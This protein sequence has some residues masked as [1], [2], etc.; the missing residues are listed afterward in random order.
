[1]SESL[2]PTKQALLVIKQLQA[3]IEALERA[4]HE[5]I[6]IIGIGCRFP[7]GVDNPAAFWDLLRNGRDAIVEIPKNRW[8]IE[9]LY[10]SNPNTAGKMYTRHGGF[11]PHLQEFDA[12][13]FGISPREAASLDPQQRLLLE[14]TWEALENAC[15][16]P[17]QLSD[18]QTGVF[19]GICGND[20]WH[21]LLSRKFTEIDAYLATGN[22]H[23]IASGRLSY[24]LGCN[25][26]S[27]S[28]D[29]ACS[30]SLVALHLAV[31]SLRHQ[32]CHVA[33][34]GG[35][36]RIILPQVSINFSKA[37]MLSPDGSCKT[38]DAAANGFVRGEGCGII[39]LKRMSDAVASGDRI[40][41]V[42]LGSAVNHDG[43]SSGL[44]VP[45]GS[46]QEKLIQQALNN[47]GVEPA[48]ID[49]IETHGTG[50]ALGD[51]IE[52]GALG[53]IFSQKAR[54]DRPLMVGSVKTN[55]GHLEAAAGIAGLIKVVLALQKEE[56][57][58]H[59]HFQKPNPHI[60]WDELQ[61]VVPTEV[62]SW[63]KNA[64]Q[65]LA[66]VSSFG[67][68]G[69][70]AHAI[71][72]EAPQI[73][74]SDSLDPRPL[75]ILTISAKSDPA[76]RELAK[77]YTIW[78]QSTPEVSLADVCFT[79]NTGRS[80][81]NYRLSILASSIPEM[82]AK[83]AG[84]SHG[85]KDPGLFSGRVTDSNRPKVV[86]LFTGAGFQS[87]DVRHL[88]E[89]QP[90]FRSHIDY[91]AEI[92]EP[93]LETSL[94]EVLYPQN[95]SIKINE[96]PFPGLALFSLQYA[97]FQLWKSWGI[98]PG[99]VIGDDVGEY[100]AACVAGVFSL[101][102]G[103]KLMVVR[104][105]LI[106]QGLGITQEKALSHFEA[107]IQE[108]KY[109]KPVIPFISLLTGE[110][111]TDEIALADY[112]RDRSRFS[113]KLDRGINY[114]HEAGFR[115]FLEITFLPEIRREY[116]RENQGVWLSSLHPEVA[117]WQQMLTTL[118]Q[119]YLQGVPVD[120][121][122]FHRDYP[123]HRVVLPTYPFQR[124]RYWVELSEKT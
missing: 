101:E 91:C 21:H 27:L 96:T 86:F 65:R 95:K 24:I 107:G 67:F 104:E 105:K 8:N 41:A 114:L 7:G 79:S 40:L 16:V 12:Q 82:L 88:Y 85:E 15:I 87:L 76:L 111:A 14:V 53:R 10:D 29:T 49:Y 113:L 112:W 55:I 77:K 99:A 6:A 2:S 37:R 121:L 19:M 20:Y 70:N 110:F 74:K 22:S 56:I 102:D 13:F 59:L 93:D 42:I 33:I 124:Q 63:Q 97:L 106:Q 45:N 30:S 11:V 51:P 26:P 75:H 108:V 117:D 3:K 50:T 64:R 5:A 119:L 4:N 68:S 38:F 72:G 48:Q 44:T 34:V 115:I 1:M 39:V 32:E 61:L 100:V 109:S 46:S 84:F 47:S 90:T 78:L 103:L 62:R 73:G 18:S 71:L 17:N 60:N 83:L 52:I 116:P 69:T 36:N 43:K 81:F 28:I 123:C 120:W 89:T 66:G 23:S 92:L 118:V 122:G 57:P 98:E 94:L 80:H 9:A 25:G 35:V 54:S 58:P 31:T